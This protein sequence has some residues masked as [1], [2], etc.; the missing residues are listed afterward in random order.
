M[1]NQ[2]NG[3]D[4]LPS[5]RLFDRSLVIGLCP[6]TF[7]CLHPRDSSSEYVLVL[8]G[9]PRITVKTPV[10]KIPQMLRRL[11]RREQREAHHSSIV[12]TIKNL[13]IVTIFRL[14]NRRCRR[15]SMS[16]LNTLLCVHLTPINVIIS[17][18][19][20]IP[21][22]EVGFPLRCFQRLSIPDIATQRCTK[23]VQLP[24]QRSVRFGPLVLET[25][26]LKNRRLQ[27]IGDQPVSRMFSTI[28]RCIGLD[29]YPNRFG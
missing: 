28:A 3:N 5:E 12:V 18:G 6:L 22:L 19:S 20:M 26:L 16:R 29:L 21:N 4:G 8:A 23:A 13:T 27:Q 17:H 1:F 10:H 24:H 25:T 11:T 14:P 15:I 9:S 7:L 2:K